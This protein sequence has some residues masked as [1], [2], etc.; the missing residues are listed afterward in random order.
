MKIV[1]LYLMFIST[2]DAET[3]KVAGDLLDF[4]DH[5]GLLVRG[6][7]KKCEALKAVENHKK[8]DLKKVRAG[9]KFTNS[10]GSD[11]CDKVYQAQALLGVNENQDQRAFCYFKDNSFIEMN[12]LTNYLVDKKIVSE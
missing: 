4:R 10:I 9:M 2:A 5:E 8:I 3:F 6:C 7:D 1:I 11:V 12:S